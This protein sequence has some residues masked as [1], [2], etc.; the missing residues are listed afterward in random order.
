MVDWN[1]GSANAERGIDTLNTRVEYKS[2]KPATLSQNKVFATFTCEK[3]TRI[4]L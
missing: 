4:V 3:A 1:A 2:L